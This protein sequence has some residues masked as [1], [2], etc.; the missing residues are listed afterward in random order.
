MHRIVITR[1]GGYS[2][3]EYVESPD[4]VPGRGE[5]VIATQ[6][7]GLNY[8]DGIIRMG[9]YESAKQLQAIRSRRVSKSPDGW[10]R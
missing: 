9:L 5:V 8:A 10:R 4:P 2:T 3:L 6:A 7:C 1:P